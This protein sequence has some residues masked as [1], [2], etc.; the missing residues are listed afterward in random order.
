MIIYKVCKECQNTNEIQNVTT[1]KM[2]PSSSIFMQA[3]NSCY[4]EPFAFQ[5]PVPPSRRKNVKVR[6]ER[7]IRCSSDNMSFP[8]DSR[9]IISN[10]IGANKPMIFLETCY[11]Y[12]QKEPDNNKYCNKL[13]EAQLCYYIDVEERL[14]QR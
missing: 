6:M 10:N 8:Q 9:S 1:T 14:G 4:T 11:G 3:Q 5:A 12:S 13:C 7:V 2:K